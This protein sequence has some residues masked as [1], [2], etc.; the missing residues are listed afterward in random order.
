MTLLTA[1]AITRLTWA[2]PIVSCDQIPA[3][4]LSFFENLNLRDGSGFPYIVQT[5][6]YK[7]YIH[8]TSEKYKTGEKLVCLIGGKLY[9][10][11][12]ERN[13]LRSTCYA[14][15]DIS[16]IETGTEL[17]YTWIAISGIDN[18]GIL[19]FSKFDFNTVTDYLFNPI[20]QSF[21]PAPGNFTD[22]Q[23][24]A[25]RAKFNYL[26]ELNYKF[27]NYARRSI[28]PGQKV[29]QSVLQP[30]MREPIFSLF[31]KTF[32]RTITPAHFIILTDTELITITDVER[33]KWD[34][35]EGYR[36][37][38]HY[39]PLTKIVSVSQ[40][41][42]GGVFRLSIL[43]P[44]NESLVSILQADKKY[45]VESLLEKFQAVRN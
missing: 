25:E 44:E 29:I 34:K 9:I 33:P 21:R 19:T 36:S 40:E 12:K 20:F 11:V 22:A 8:Q 45:E 27:M 14:F 17:L 24:A 13:E 39:I 43:L 37:I 28:L 31:G 18:R 4:Y 5:P 42:E 32:Y 30:E 6:S 10:L 23:F 3:A 16:Y 1:A 7:G 38:W 2:K 41:E 15:E 35:Y 26:F